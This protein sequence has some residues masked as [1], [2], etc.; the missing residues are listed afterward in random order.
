MS[1]S[2]Y[3]NYSCMAENKLGTGTDSIFLSGTENIRLLSF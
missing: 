1:E 3:G 2:D